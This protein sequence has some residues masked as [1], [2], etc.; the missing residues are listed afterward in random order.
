MKISSIVARR[1]LAGISAGCLLGGITLG[2]VGAPSAA[3]T[4]DCS[5]GGVNA[6]VSSVQGSAEQY[7]AAHPGANQVVTAAYTQPR[8]DA[9]SNLR[10]YFTA[11]PQEYYDLRG[12]LAPIGDTERQCN[13]QALPPTLESA[14]QE[15]MAG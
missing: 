11:H 12:I 7:L 15:F 5:P 3:A 2:I 14:Y 6:T 4:P 8:P 1:R 9:A 13:V 10:S